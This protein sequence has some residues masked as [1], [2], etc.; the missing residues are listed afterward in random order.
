MDGQLMNIKQIP[1]LR[2]DTMAISVH[3]MEVG[4]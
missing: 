4:V 1:R 3:N 2:A